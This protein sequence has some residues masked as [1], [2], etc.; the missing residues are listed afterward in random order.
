MSILFHAY[1]LARPALFAMDAETAHEVTLSGLQRAY[2]C[3]A[4]RKLM[5]AQPK[6]PCTLMGMQLENPIGL[7][8]GLDKNGAYIDA[9]GNLGFGFIEVG[10]VTPRAQPGN[11]K[12]RMFRL[13]RANALIN[14]LGFNNQGLPAFLANV[15]RSQWRKQGGILGLN[16]GKNADTPIERAADD[17][18]IG[19]EGVYPHADYVT[20]NISSPNTK[21]LRALQSG[22]ELSALLAQLADKRRALEDQHQ[23]RVP[24]A[25][26]IAP[27]LTQEQIDAIADTLP[28]HGIDGVIA[29]NTTLSRD[30]VAGQAHAEEAGGLSGAPVHEL[31]LKVIRRLKEQLGN[32]LAI[33]GVGGVLSGQQA[34]EKMAA[35]ADAVQLYTGLIYR[36]PALV[37]ECV[38]ATAKR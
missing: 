32:S 21:N 15:Q 1:P 24:M 26:K 3:G 5:H 25:V 17:Y 34:R 4:T 19:L 16:I 14:R 9:L 7:A 38:R 27:D 11:P 28:R 23:R 37:G 35:G 8:A 31:S 10:T 12:P 13:P 20:V 6:A 22:D 29:T 2:E 18:L 36:G 33:I 30:A